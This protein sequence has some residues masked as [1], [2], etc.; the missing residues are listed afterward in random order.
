MDFIHSQ[1]STNSA[2][3]QKGFKTISICGSRL[4]FSVLNQC[5]AQ[6]YFRGKAFMSMWCLSED[7][8]RR[9]VDMKSFP[10]QECTLKT[11]GIFYFCFHSETLNEKNPKIHM[12]CRSYRSYTRSRRLEMSIKHLKDR[13]SPVFKNNLQCETISKP[14]CVA[15]SHCQHVCTKKAQ[16]I[17]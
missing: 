1:R 5:T 8:Y 3:L 9:A 17:S 15:A 7:L 11:T 14:A 16:L 13:E 12:E 6:S 2:A 10:K 4:W